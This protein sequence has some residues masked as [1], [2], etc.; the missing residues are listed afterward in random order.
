MKQTIQEQITILSDVDTM[1]I[2]SVT[3]TSLKSSI[4][5]LASK[6]ST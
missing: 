6:K 5:S 2:H 4:S 3:V 1:E